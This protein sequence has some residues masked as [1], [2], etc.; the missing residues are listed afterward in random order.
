MKV[1][2]VVNPRGTV[3][4]VEIAVKMVITVEGM[5]TNEDEPDSEYE[6]G[7]MDEVPRKTA[8]TKVCEIAVRAAVSPPFSVPFVEQS[9]KGNKI[10]ELAAP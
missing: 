7:E 6:D 8:N 3:K 1:K 9:F 2:I 5:Q 4:R 10:T